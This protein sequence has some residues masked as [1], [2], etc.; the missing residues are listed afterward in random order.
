MKDLTEAFLLCYKADG[1]N[2]YGSFE[3]E[4]GVIEE[5]RRE[6][7]KYIDWEKSLESSMQNKERSEDH[8]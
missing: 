3:R 4:K 8:V 1:M 2:K 6:V 7:K 5:G